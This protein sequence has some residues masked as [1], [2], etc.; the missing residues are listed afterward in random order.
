MITGH[1][2]GHDPF[3]QVN[4]IAPQGKH[5]HSQHSQRAEQE[6]EQE[7]NSSYVLEKALAVDGAQSEQGEP[8]VSVEHVHVA[9]A[10]PQDASPTGG[11][12][13]LHG[14]DQTR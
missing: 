10:T 7:A 2:Q 11:D 9:G 3:A 1:E 6:Q 5:D 8:G 14:L 4:E 13:V 12:P